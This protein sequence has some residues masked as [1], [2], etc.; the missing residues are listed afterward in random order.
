LFEKDN[1]K[2]FVELVEKAIDYANTHTISNAAK[3]KK[4][5][6]L[7]RDFSVPTN[8][9][10]PTMKLKRNKVEENFR[11]EIEKVYEHKAH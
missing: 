3:I 8:E 4:W 1:Y 2:K 5:I 10:T 11:E 9:L 6:L 7:K